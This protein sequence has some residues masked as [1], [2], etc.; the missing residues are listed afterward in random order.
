MVRRF[1]VF[2]VSIEGVSEDVPRKVPTSNL[3]DD[4]EVCEEKPPDEQ[5]EQVLAYLEQ[6][7]PGSRRH[8]EYA[9]LYEVGNRVGCLHGIDIVDVDLEEQ[10]IRFRHR[11]AEDPEI[12][13]TP[14]KNGSD[15]ERSVNISNELADVIRQYLSNPDR[16]DVTDKFDREPLLTT[17]SGRPT[18]DTIRRDLYKLTRPCV[19]SNTC[20]HDRDIETC[21]ATKSANASECPSS[22]SPHPL[23]R[24]SIEQQIDRGVPKDELCDRVDVSVPVLNK[25]YDTRSE[26]RK[27]KQRLETLEKLYEG[28]GDPSATLGDEEL[29]ALT[30]N[31]GMID[32]VAL[33]QLINTEKQQQD[34]PPTQPSNTEED[35]EIQNEDQHSLSDFTAS[36]SQPLVAPLV[37]IFITANWMPDRL[38][39]ELND[40]IPPEERSPWPNTGR[41]AKGTA[42]YALYVCL[43]SVNLILTGVFPA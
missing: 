3:S 18:V 42:A 8:V 27:R 2:C 14:L 13:G 10:V 24:W 41:M 20:P 26:E 21:E 30:D 22:H 19:H 28:Y 16:Y 39:R 7:E 37:G 12:K 38:R 4:M 25:H 6:Y 11:P 31:D 9:V 35:S 43:V 32:P 5:V 15:G 36:V 23:R 34:S 1:L 17:E 33:R 40:L 29:V